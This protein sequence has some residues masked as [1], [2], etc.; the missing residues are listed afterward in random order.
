MIQIA[1]AK[2]HLFFPYM[3][4]TS[5]WSV[6][7]A[8]ALH[9]PDFRKVCQIDKLFPLSDLP[10]YSDKAGTVFCKTTFMV[11]ESQESLKLRL[12]DAQETGE[13]F[14]NRKSAGVCIDLTP[15]IQK[16]RNTH[17]TEITN[18]LGTQIR[19]RLFQY[20]VIKPFGLS[21]IQWEESFGKG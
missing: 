5:D 6:A 21:G 19:D 4:R 8:D 1:S 20:L 16:G 18:T 10:S 11:A 13:I 9:Y 15:Y 2:N 12:I 7:F 14:I 17:R 3:S